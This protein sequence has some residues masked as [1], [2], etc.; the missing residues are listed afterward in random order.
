MGELV[1]R[2]IFGGPGPVLKP[3]GCVACGSEPETPAGKART[4]KVSSGRKG[5]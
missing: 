1:L 3:V 2:P 5:P 4:A